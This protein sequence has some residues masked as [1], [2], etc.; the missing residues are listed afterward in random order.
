LGKPPFQRCHILDGT[1]AIPLSSFS[2]PFMLRRWRLQKETPLYAEVEPCIPL[3]LK[4]I[5]AQKHKSR[6]LATIWTALSE[7]KFPICSARWSLRQPKGIRSSPKPCTTNY[8]LQPL[9]KLFVNSWLA[10]YQWW[11]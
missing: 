2:E 4:L 3:A 10:P 11:S 9:F 6:L 5:H 8:S 1:S 7:T